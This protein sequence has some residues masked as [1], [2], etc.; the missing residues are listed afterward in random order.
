M[1]PTLQGPGL[2]P[3]RGAYAFEAG[4]PSPEAPGIWAALCP[5]SV[6]CEAMAS[7]LMVLVFPGPWV[8][9]MLVRVTALVSWVPAPEMPTH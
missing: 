4:P 2:G 5:A 7:C 6:T 9:W 3:L 1:L 8:T